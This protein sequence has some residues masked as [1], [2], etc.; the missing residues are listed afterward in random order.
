[1]KKIKA[2]K[3]PHT[4]IGMLIYVCV[5]LFPGCKKDSLTAEESSVTGV[6]VYD[7]NS[8]RIPLDIVAGKGFM[9]S[10]YYTRE[11]PFY[12]FMLTDNSG[13]HLW[14]KDFGVTGVTGIL[15]ENDGTFTIFDNAR[16]INIDVNGSI[17]KDIPDFLSEISGYLTLHVTLNSDGNY[18]FYGSSSVLN[19]YAFAFEITH[20]GVTV[21][22][23]SYV[24]G[25]IFTGCRQTPDG[26]YMFFGNRYLISASLPT[27]FFLCKMS[28]VGVVDWIKYHTP[29][30]GGLDQGPNYLYTHDILESGEGNYFCFVG[31]SELDI[32]HASRIYKVSPDGMLLDSTDITFSGKNILAGRNK[33]GYG[34]GAYPGVNGYC[35]VKKPDGTYKVFLNNSTFEE[36]IATA[37]LL[38]GNKS[39]AVNFN[40]DLSFEKEEYLQNRYPDYFTA[41][42]LN[43]D[44]RT[45]AFG[46]I[47]S[48][49]NRNKP[50]ILI[51]E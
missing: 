6:K 2:I 7:D 36:E 12:R 37:E 33:F 13:N 24:A 30:G 42:C 51:T 21:F 45:V 27:S 34:I 25:T 11:A 9:L 16:L 10:A 39:F 50:I 3:L 35:S 28:S 46:Y 48:L 38:K 8:I 5:L 17:L 31:Q 49:G 15:A 1:M 43:S 23:K 32:D 20:S 18:F 22:K 47:S 44:G 4:Y 29:P 26:G 41:V 19:L 14:T 40:D